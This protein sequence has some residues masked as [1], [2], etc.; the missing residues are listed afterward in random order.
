MKKSLVVIHI[1]F[2]RLKINPIFRTATTAENKDTY[3][4][5]QVVCMLGKGV[6][7]PGT[8]SSPSKPPPPPACSSSMPFH[9]P[10]T[11]PFQSCLSRI[12]YP[13]SVM[14]GSKDPSSSQY[15]FLPFLSIPALHEQDGHCV[16]HFFP[17]S[18]NL[19]P[20]PEK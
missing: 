10:S 7:C 12:P 14:K 6:F 3:C 19:V 9:I 5:L 8:R 13:P 4:R 16:Y 20:F 15:C 11:L 1:I 18:F 2:S 17:V